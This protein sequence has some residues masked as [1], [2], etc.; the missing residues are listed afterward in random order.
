MLKYYYQSIYNDIK[1]H[2]LEMYPE[3]C[4]GLVVQTE[5]GLVYIPCCNIADNKI[6]HFEMDVNDY[7]NATYIGHVLAIIHSHIN[8]PH[9]SKHDM[10][11]QIRHDIPYGII[12][13]KNGQTQDICFWGDTLPIQTY[14]GRPFRHG[15]YDC[16]SLVRDYHRGDLNII[17]VEVPREYKWWQENDNL[18][19]ESMSKTGFVVLDKAITDLAKNDV[20]IMRI[21]SKM[22]NHCGVYLGNNL[23][24]HH[25]CLHKSS[26]SKVEP[27]SS[28]DI[29][30]ITHIFRHKELI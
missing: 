19:L 14:V 30:N 18:I 22:P 4:C 9:A 6:E 16:W 24:L 13:L 1:I 23:V 11:E 8:Y 28:L 29:K 26:L 10:E 17:P 7:V 21:N 20:I 5:A 27:L 3:E 25:L 12:N 2:A 15:I